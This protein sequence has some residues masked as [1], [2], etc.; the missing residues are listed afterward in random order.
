MTIE[1]ELPEEL[2]SATVSTQLGKVGT[3]PLGFAASEFRISPPLRGLQINDTMIIPAY[4][5]TGPV[6]I[7]GRSYLPAAP[8]PLVREWAPPAPHPARTRSA[9]PLG[10][11]LSVVLLLVLL[12]VSSVGL[13][14]L[15]RHATWFSSLQNFAPTNAPSQIVQSRAISSQVVLVSS[16]SAAITYGV[17]AESYA[18]ALTIDHPCW[19]VV[20]SP[21]N[22]ATLLVAKTF[23][24]GA[25]PISIPVHGS[26]SVTVSARVRSLSI[27][28]GSSTLYSI[29]SPRLNVAYTFTRQSR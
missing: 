20:K 4:E 11:R 29:A 3:A 6:A 24:P 16:S 5:I 26:A 7:V 21:A 17:P 15:R 19:V 28:E 22:S 2:Q 14:A 13:A 9:A 12:L 25:S 8:Q 23:A 27:V 18:I 1:K 10:L